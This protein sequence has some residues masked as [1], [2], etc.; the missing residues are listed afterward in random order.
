MEKFEFDGELDSSLS[1]SGGMGGWDQFAV[2]KQV[3]A[4][5]LILP[6]SLLPSLCR[7]LARARALSLSRAPSVC[8]SLSR[9]LCFSLSWHHLAV[10]KHV[11]SS[12]KHTVQNWREWERSLTQQLDTEIRS[13]FRLP[14]GDVH[15]E[16]GPD[17]DDGR[18]ANQGREDSTRDRGLLSVISLLACC[19]HQYEKTA[20]EIEVF[21]LLH[22]KR[23]AR[24]HKMPLATNPSCSRTSF[25]LLV[26]NRQDEQRRASG[27]RFRSAD[28]AEA[29]GDDQGDEWASDVR[30]PDGSTRGRYAQVWK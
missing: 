2:N 17:Q 29:A 1:L 22:C 14:G 30:A 16:T 11:A 6:P 4:L 12:A 10:I 18:A 9:S 28:E 26:T 20:R 24:D 15:D 7:F 5:S 21:Y 27:G 13:H 8:F 3:A 25:T 23:Q 19:K